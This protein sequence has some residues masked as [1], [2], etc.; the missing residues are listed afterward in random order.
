MKLQKFNQDKLL[1]VANVIQNNKYLISVSN[2]LMATLPIL[3]IG[4]ISTILSSMP[5]EPYQDF[6]TNIGIKEALAL[7]ANLT[8]NIMALYV[9]FFVAYRL[10]ESHDHDA[11][12]AGTISLIC[13][14]VLTPFQ[15][16]KELQYMPFEWLGA[17]GLFVAMIVGVLTTWIYMKIVDR[18]LV[19]KMPE[20]VPPTVQKTFASI[21]PGIVIVALITVI[22]TIFKATSFGSIHQF[23]Y[24]FLQ[25]PMQHV[26][27][28]YWGL[29]TFVTVA[30][31][32][33]LFGIHGS[34]VTNVVAK[35]LLL[36]MDLANLAAFQAGE[37]LPFVISW[38]FRFLYSLIGGGGCTL[39]LCLL[40]AFRAK[41]QQ[42]R[43][44]GKIALPTSFFSINEPLIF[45]IP[46]VLNPILTIP[47][48]LTPIVT[49]TLAYL[50]TISGLIPTPIGVFLPTGTP[51]LFSAFVQG[52]IILVLFQLL[53]I[54]VTIVCYYPFFKKLDK[55]RCAE[56]ETSNDEAD[57]S[58]AK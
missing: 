4:A 44:I 7:P 48:I 41:S 37:P 10:A 51:V 27:G 14:L 45:G 32:L 26:G 52:G 50:A 6:I 56:E 57:V 31:I 24:T 9:A 47:F 38:A 49:M 17:K 54:A 20:S 25:I 34:M 35:P 55:Q 58:I 23:I 3:I 28:S 21:F 46:V 29:L 43:A 13:F 39:G 16:I 18:N 1:S 33:W 5:F 53:M 30:N 11:L 8:T 36:S 12:A 15:V 40:L 22:A 42:L 19:I 2:G